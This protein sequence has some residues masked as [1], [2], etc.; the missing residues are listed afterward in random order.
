MRR[1]KQDNLRRF[2][3]ILVA[4]FVMFQS[5]NVWAG[6]IASTTEST[7]DA[8]H[9]HTQQ[10]L[11]DAQSQTKSKKCQKQCCEDMQH[12]QHK[13]NHNCLH[14]VSA[15]ALISIQEH[16]LAKLNTDNSSVSDY[17]LQG[18][19]AGSIYRPPRTII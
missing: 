2:S 16:L 7:I 5:M 4:V 15:V 11:T 8:P 19:D 3:N 10:L 14:A 13:C 1:N 12:C 17:P 6:I 9:C 18:I